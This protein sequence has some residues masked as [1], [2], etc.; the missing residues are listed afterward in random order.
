MEENRS[1]LRPAQ[2]DLS[3]MSEVPVAD[4]ERV[5]KHGSF[6]GERLFAERRQVYE[7]LVWMLGQGVPKLRIA[8]LLGVSVNTV[9]AVSEREGETVGALKRE[10]AKQARYGCSLLVESVL[11]DLSDEERSKKV[12]A[13][14][15]AIIAGIFKDVA[16]QMDGE[17]QQRIELLVRPPG[18]EEYNR[19]LEDL[20]EAAVEELDMGAVG[21]VCDE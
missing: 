4:V 19:E 7:S 8:K 1:L 20:K 13:K 2:Q 21:E 10:I 6:S 15:K 3:L 9:R 5:S 14:D 11:E 17:S 18:H 16:A 12:S